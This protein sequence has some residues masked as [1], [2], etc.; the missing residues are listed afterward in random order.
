MK[1][2]ELQKEF[3]KR[4][5]LFT[6]IEKKAKHTMDAD[7]NIK[8]SG[9]CIYRCSALHYDD[10]YYEI[11]K[12]RLAKPHPYDNGDWDMVEVYPGDEQFGVWAWTVNDKSYIKDV[13]KRHFDLFFKDDDDLKVSE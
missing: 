5:I 6:Q 1:I 10:V 2:R 13:I 3:K 4:G 7:G 11:F 8:T 9:Y 12:Y